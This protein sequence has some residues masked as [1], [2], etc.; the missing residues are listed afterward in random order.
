ME[1]DTLLHL[2]V[3]RNLMIR[4][5]TRP[6][7][8]P[9]PNP[10]PNLFPP[11]SICI[12]GSDL[13]ALVY[14]RGGSCSW[15][16]FLTT[17]FVIASV[18]W[19]MVLS[20]TVA[21]VLN[22][23][24][25]SSRLNRLTSYANVRGGP[26]RRWLA[27]NIERMRMLAFH[28]LVWG[29]ATVCSVSM[30]I[31]ADEQRAISS[32]CWFDNSVANDDAAAAADTSE[33]SSAASDSISSTSPDIAQVCL[34][35]VP[36]V[37]SILYNCKTLFWASCRKTCG[38]LCSDRWR[39]V[40]LIGHETNENVLQQHVDNLISK[41]RYYIMLSVVVSVWLCIAEIVNF[42]DPSRQNI[43]WI[44]SVMLI[45]LRLHGFGN[46]MIYA[47]RKDVRRAWYKEVWGFMGWETHLSE[48]ELGGESKPND[49][50]D[51]DEEGGGGG[52]GD[53]QGFSSGLQVSL[54]GSRGESGLSANSDPD[55]KYTVYGASVY[56]N[57]RS[58]ELVTPLYKDRRSRSGSGLGIDGRTHSDGRNTNT[59]SAPPVRYSIASADTR[60]TIGSGHSLGSNN[61]TPRE[62]ITLDITDDDEEGGV[63]SSYNTSHNS[64]TAASSAYA[65]YVPPSDAS[66]ASLTHSFIK[67]LQAK[68]PL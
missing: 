55:N 61:S 34:F 52:D 38:T 33:A 14:I 60:S 47:S 63:H 27:N 5:S 57:E 35:F 9:N 67:N 36:I 62:S 53:D 26:C 10:Y 29:I 41:L 1:W 17:F 7:L 56:E 19:S 16:S 13:T 6:H 12:A 66:P 31:Q 37:A 39:D 50:M 11:R 65:G 51:G 22:R 58:D 25:L 40:A 28:T 18:L 48:A 64:A 8:H 30:S 49:F 15:Y 54:G 23:D 20:R 45:M 24:N 3:C 59:T 21:L 43:V 32:W 44:Y 68:T 2:P 46:L 42:Y 4:K